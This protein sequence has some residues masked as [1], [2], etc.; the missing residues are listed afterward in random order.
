MMPSSR[1]KI[2]YMAFEK[3][4]RVAPTQLAS[5][6]QTE[7]SDSIARD[8]PEEVAFKLTNRCNL[9]CAHC[10]QWSEDG[11]HHNLIPWEQH[12]DLDL[13]VI[14]KVLIATQGIK[15]NLFIWG[16]EPLVYREWD[17]LI[18]LLEWSDRWTSVCTNGMLIRRRLQ[19]ILRVSRRL[20]MFIALD[21]FENEHDALRGT[22]TFKKTMDGVR[23]LSAAKRKG[24]YH[25][26]VTVNCVIQDSMID[27]LF[28]FVSF[29]QTEGVDAIYISFPWY[30][31]NDT[32]Q[33]MD[34]Y[35]AQHLPWLGE[36]IKG[37]EASWHSYTFQIDPSNADKLNREI[38]RINS[39]EWR[40]KVRY[41]PA[42]DRHEMEEFL[43][44]SH[45]PAQNKTKCLALR[46]RIDVYPSGQAVSCHL[47]PE[48]SVGDL[49][50]ADLIEVWRGERYNSV[51]KT[52]DSCGLMPV[53]AKCNLLY[54][55]GR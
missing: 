27:S 46:S 17:G 23:L 35:I 12:C 54:T 16:G 47:F 4:R 10:Y 44:G 3:M 9:R 25:G 22:G 42:L 52:V 19:S 45:R 28:D 38:D 11:Y 51:R 49:T 26:E 1:S 50:K 34:S 7:L 55:R 31:S 53:C 14:K 20:E 33:M 39:E 18:E 41:N 6:R 21:G 24:S 30:I 36:S 32:A 43:R 48:L 29:L 8:L 37:T 40:I 15:S 2:D 5:R 13:S